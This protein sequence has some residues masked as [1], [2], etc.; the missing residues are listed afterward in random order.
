MGLLAAIWIFLW[1]E[2]CA[3]S[4]IITIMLLHLCRTCQTPR[5]RHPVPI[6]R[7]RLPA[8]M[9]GQAPPGLV[10]LVHSAANVPRMD[11]IGHAD[12]YGELWLERGGAPVGA[13]HKIHTC[14]KEANPVPKPNCNR[15]TLSTRIV[16]LFVPA[17]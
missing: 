7:L 3:Q 1:F 8:V 2:C 10:V 4:A 15:C 16:K 14:W 5:T 6:L 12:V 11:M 13:H 9:A 17:M